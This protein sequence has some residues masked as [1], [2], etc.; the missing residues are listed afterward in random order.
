MEYVQSCLPELIIL[1][2]T[3]ISFVLY[4]V[5]LCKRDGLR[6]V[7]LRAILE[8]ERQYNSTTGKERLSFAVDYVYE[9]LPKYIKIILPKLILKDFLQR[10]IQEVFNQVKDL[11]DY[12][13]GVDL[14]EEI[15]K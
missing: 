5:Y 11:L 1:I 3:I 8:A 7:A 6:S 2:L 9:Y 10:F 13:K 14:I 4:I 15:K 12:E